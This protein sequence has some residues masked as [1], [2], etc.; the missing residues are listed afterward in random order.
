MWIGSS[1]SRKHPLAG[2]CEHGDEHLGSID[3]VNFLSSGATISLSRRSDFDGYLCG[4]LSRM[5]ILHKHKFV[6]SRS[7]CVSHLWSVTWLTGCSSRRL[8]SRYGTCPAGWRQL[9]PSCSWLVERVWLYLKPALIYV[10]YYII[11]T[12][13]LDLSTIREVAT[14]LTTPAILGKMLDGRI[15][16]T[17]TQ[18][19]HSCID[20]SF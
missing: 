18:S 9:S 7:A 15:V 2:F 13:H 19:V 1:G 8:A 11:A 17:H 5:S 12:S 20:S 16:Y 4:K 6:L 10:H 3:S 14:F